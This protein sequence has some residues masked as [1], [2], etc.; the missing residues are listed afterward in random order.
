MDLG[1]AGSIPVAHPEII[2]I[3]KWDQRVATGLEVSLVDAT[4]GSIFL[5][6][7]WPTRSVAEGANSRS[8][9]EVR[10]H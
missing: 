5:R 6:G 2:Y 4:S 10:Q 7:E 9:N 1:V 3:N 8:P